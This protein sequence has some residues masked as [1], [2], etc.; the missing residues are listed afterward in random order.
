MLSYI[1]TSWKTEKCLIIQLLSNFFQNF[2]NS[3][4]HCCLQINTT[5]FCV[6]IVLLLGYIIDQNVFAFPVI[7]G[8]V[9]NM[10]LTFGVGWN[11]QSWVSWNVL[12]L[13]CSLVNLNLLAFRRSPKDIFFL[14][15]TAT[16]FIVIGLL[17]SK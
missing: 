6:N 11:T 15:Q 4:P 17:L 8:K 10:H 1:I 2:E 16:L 3:F 14:S 13:T 5:C 7:G 12:Q 9:K